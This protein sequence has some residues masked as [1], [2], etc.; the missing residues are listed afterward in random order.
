M[1]KINTQRI[2]IGSSLESV[3]FA[4]K[5][6]CTLILNKVNPPEIYEAQDALGRVVER[7]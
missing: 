7:S 4:S 1:K 2:V 5:N 6:N 3:L